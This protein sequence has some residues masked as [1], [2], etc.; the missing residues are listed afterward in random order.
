MGFRG[1]IVIFSLL[2]I[3]CERKVDLP[4]AVLPVPSERQ[5]K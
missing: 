3:S 4:E 5:L 2:L 1:F